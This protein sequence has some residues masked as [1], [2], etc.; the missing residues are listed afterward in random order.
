MCKKI[1]YLNLCEWF[2]GS[3]PSAKSICTNT[4]RIESE[5]LQRL[6]RKA[7]FAGKDVCFAKNQH[8]VVVLFVLHCIL[9]NSW[10]VI[11]FLSSFAMP[12]LFAM[13]ALLTG[14]LLD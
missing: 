10:L 12:P 9:F 2:V 4:F 14:N 7:T 3:L 5:F 13:S 6:C 11:I 8:D 1:M